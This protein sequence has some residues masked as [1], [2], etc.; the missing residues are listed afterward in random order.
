M[1]AK[2][3][4]S[5]FALTALLLAWFMLSGP[6]RAAD[7]YWIGSGTGDWDNSSNWSL[8]DG[9]S[10]GAGQPQTGDNVYLPRSLTGGDLTVQYCNALNPNDQLGALYIS[11]F[12]SGP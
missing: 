4:R 10:G 5:G 2:V 3:F 6:A 11:G 1:Q 9:G 8:T 7:K 12:G